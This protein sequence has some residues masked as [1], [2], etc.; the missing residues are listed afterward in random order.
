MEY[1]GI[2]LTSSEMIR[3][4]KAILGGNIEKVKK[5]IVESNNSPLPIAAIEWEGE[6]SSINSYQL[7]Y[8]LY[9]AYAYNSDQTWFESHNI[10]AILNLHKELCP[11]L[12]HIDYSL[13]GFI[14]WNNFDL[15]DEDEIE[16][17]LK[18]GVKKCDIE[19]TNYGVQHKEKEVIELLQKGASPYYIDTTDDTFED[20]TYLCY[21]NLATLLWRLDSTWCDQWELNFLPSYAEEI[22]SLDSEELSRLLC[23]LFNAGAS[24]RMLYIIDKYID[25]N[26][27][28]KGAELLRRY[29]D[30]HPILRHK[31][32]L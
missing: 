27:R 2:R 21:Q 17:L 30:Y 19:L 11:Y 29:D 9:D 28:E 32:A 13:I 12:P 3:N 31:P 6:K 22:D 23:Y 1:M 8:A 10:K 14:S 25:D 4:A 15:Y 24:M 18:S 20:K 26:V 5:L 7:A 16:M